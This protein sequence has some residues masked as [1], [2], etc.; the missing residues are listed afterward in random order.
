ML[1][2]APELCR[3]L[4]ATIGDLRPAAQC[5]A[6]YGAA[7]ASGLSGLGESGGEAGRRAA[8]LVAGAFARRFAALGASGGRR[9]VRLESGS[10]I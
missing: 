1:A 10:L 3:P 2:T 6:E 9:R 5:L 8:G 7:L 4:A